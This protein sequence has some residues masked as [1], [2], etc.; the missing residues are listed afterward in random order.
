MGNSGDTSV[1]VDSIRGRLEPTDSDA[2]RDEVS[3][4]GVGLSCPKQTRWSVRTLRNPRSEENSPGKKPGW[5]PAYPP[6]S[7]FVLKV[8]NNALRGQN[9]TWME[10]TESG[11][12]RQTSEDLGTRE[13]SVDEQSNVGF[14]KQLSNHLGSKQQMV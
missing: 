3:R 11:L 2:G 14:G 13:G 5:L 4:V 1:V 6:R 7:P 9:R 8:E 10:S 12:T